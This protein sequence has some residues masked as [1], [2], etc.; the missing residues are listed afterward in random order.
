MTEILSTIEA[1]ITQA[2]QDN[3]PIDYT[4]LLDYHR[5]ITSVLVLT[6]GSDV[7]KLLQ[8]DE[9]FKTTGHLIA[10]APQTVCMT[11][12]DFFA[13]PGVQP[14]VGDQGQGDLKCVAMNR[15][16]LMELN[17]SVL[18]Y[19]L[20]VQRLAGDTSQLLKEMIEK[21]KND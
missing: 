6:A 16:L 5:Q 20:M 8:L 3:D 9:N 1:K 17:V 21:L 18:H 10:L 2:I 14:L 19:L 15:K 7:Q 4:E 11:D 13:K 12:E